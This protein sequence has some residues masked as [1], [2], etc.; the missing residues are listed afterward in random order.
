MQSTKHLEF[1]AIV[2]SSIYGTD[3]ALHKEIVDDI[4]RM[5]LKEKIID[6]NNLDHQMYLC[7][8]LLH[9]ADLSNP[10]RDF[11]SSRYWSEMIATEFY[12]QVE[13]EKELGLEPD[14]FMIQENCLKQTQ[15][16]IGFITYV[17]KP[18]WSALGDVYPS[19]G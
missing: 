5:A 2:E 3:M 13:R 1:W 15:S 18:L 11:K 9:C 19:L 10:V 8:A 16:E 17:G 14:A 6:I 4:K 12:N 7:R